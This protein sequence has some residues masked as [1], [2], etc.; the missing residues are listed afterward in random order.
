MKVPHPSHK[1]HR[2]RKETP[3]RKTTDASATV[4]YG[5]ATGQTKK[6]GDNYIRS[7]ERQP[8]Q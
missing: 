8:I 5:F 2:D 3:I 1:W 6:L 4:K 7:N